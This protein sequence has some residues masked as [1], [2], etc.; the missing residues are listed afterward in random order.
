MKNFSKE[1]KA[2]DLNRK[3]IIKINLMTFIALLASSALR[4]RVHKA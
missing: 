4:E 3:K 2:N 1:K